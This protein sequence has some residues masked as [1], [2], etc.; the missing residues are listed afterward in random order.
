MEDLVPLYVPFPSQ[1]SASG[2][3]DYALDVQPQIGD[4]T[5]IYYMGYHLEMAAAPAPSSIR[6]QIDSSIGDLQP[7]YYAKPVSASTPVANTKGSMLIFPNVTSQ[8]QD[9]NL[10]WPWLL[11]RT[12]QGSIQ[13]LQV[14]VGDQDLQGVTFNSLVVYFGCRLGRNS[15]RYKPLRPGDYRFSSGYISHS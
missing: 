11:V 12:P 4:V 1:A 2:A 10:N 6:L 5:E 3:V 13:R 8:S 14:R 9:V 15:S 7:L